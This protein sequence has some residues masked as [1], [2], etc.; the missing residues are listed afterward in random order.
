MQTLFLIGW[1]RWSGARPFL[2]GGKVASRVLFRCPFLL[3]DKSLILGAFLRRHQL[4]AGGGQL[5]L[6]V[7][8][9][10]AQQRYLVPSPIQLLGVRR[11]LISSRCQA[12]QFKRQQRNTPHRLDPARGATRCDVPWVPTPA[13]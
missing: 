11:R 8:K 13:G 10:G 4:G 3:V 1:W 5:A 7:L 2:L 6:R 9:F 12:D